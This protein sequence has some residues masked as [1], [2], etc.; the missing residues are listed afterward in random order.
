MFKIMETLFVAIVMAIVF[1]TSTQAFL[2]F[3]D[4]N[5]WKQMDSLAIKLANDGL[6]NLGLNNFEIER[7][8][9]VAKNQS[10]LSDKKSESYAAAYD[11]RFS[12]NNRPGRLTLYVESSKKVYLEDG[13]VV[14]GPME[15]DEHLFFA[16]Y[17][18][19]QESVDASD[20]RLATYTR[21]V[22]GL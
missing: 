1:T 6:V 2:G 9:R 20:A 19:D 15:K 21:I 3:G 8:E 18:D 17:I 5:E 13:D 22:E 12:H 4:S 16:W 11:V 10:V 7:V 14:F